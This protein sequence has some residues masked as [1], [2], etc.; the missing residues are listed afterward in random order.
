MNESTIRAATAADLDAITGIYADAVM[1]GTATYE[2]DP[3]TRAEM[4]ARFDALV[5][6]G[7]PYLVATSEGRVVG[8]AYAGPF[9][10]RPAYRFIVENSI[11]VAPD[12]KGRGVGR[13]LLHR[14]IAEAERLGFRQ[15]IAVIGDGHAESASVKLHERL[16]FRHGG[17]LDGSGYKHGRWL[18][19]VFMQLPMNGGAETDPDPESLPEKMFRSKA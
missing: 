16:G 5:A 19:T 1:Y 18:D 10:A 8:Y 13:L 7:F 3:P 11:Y 15:M 14:L 9:R 17:R 2:L 6:G 12:A 4:A